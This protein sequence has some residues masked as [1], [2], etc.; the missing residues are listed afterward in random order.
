MRLIPYVLTLLLA[1]QAQAS[2][3]ELTKTGKDLDGVALSSKA[4]VKI[5]GRETSLTTIGA[6]LRSKKISFALPSVK[7]YVAQLFL[8]QPESFVRLE[9]Q[10]LSSANKS[11]VFAI[12]LS[13]LRAVEAEKVMVAFRDSLKANAVDFS[14]GEVAEFLRAVEKGGEAQSGKNLVIVGERLSDGTEVIHYE[15]TG[16]KLYSV[17][18]APGFMNKILSIWLGVPADGGLKDLRKALVGGA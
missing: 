13:F 9:D 8:S 6:G 5:D 7:V 14:K 12:Q 10:A 18:G 16:E 11:T 2:V 1:S 17:V 3:I 15:T 4:I